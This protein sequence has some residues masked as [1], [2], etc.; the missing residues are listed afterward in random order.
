MSPSNGARFSLASKGR[1]QHGSDILKGRYAD[2]KRP[3][4]H[5]TVEAKAN[6]LPPF[7]LID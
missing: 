1:P 6:N 3:L 4:L 7:Q 5:A 2:P